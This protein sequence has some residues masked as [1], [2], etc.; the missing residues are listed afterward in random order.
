MQVACQRNMEEAEATNI[1][2]MAVGMRDPYWD[3]AAEYPDTDRKDEGPILSF[4]RTIPGK[5]HKIYLL[6]TRPGEKV[7]QP[8]AHRGDLT[9]RVLTG[10]YPDARVETRPLDGFDPSDYAEAYT[11][12]RK[13]IEQIVTENVQ[14]NGARYITNLSPGTP[15]MG[16]ALAVLH[17]EGRLPGEL[18]QTKAQVGAVTVSLAPLFEDELKSV[19]LSLMAT[20][21]YMAAS[22]LLSDIAGRSS[23][24]ERKEVA[25]AMA[26]IT[27]AYYWREQ[28]RYDLAVK[29]MKVAV[30][31]PGLMRLPP[32]LQALFESQRDT[33]K[34][35]SSNGD[36]L[37]ERL[38]DQHHLATLKHARDENAVCIQHCYM[39]VEQIEE[40]HPPG[41]PAN[42][43]KEREWLR[44]KR[45]RVAHEPRGT[46]KESAGR[47]LKFTETL[48]ASR[49]RNAR[50]DIQAY[51]LCL[52]QLRQ[53]LGAV[54]NH[55]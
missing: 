50:Q 16:V 31:L 32:R 19:V 3:D 41:V 24:P 9:S 53:V 43:Q 45:N 55:L 26:H 4:F 48:I 12:I 37:R 30:G 47:A 8:T 15:Q 28:F 22:Q 21:S 20:H 5:P 38:I 27:E 33:L 39:I 23:F 25:N 40:L 34:D 14:T 36:A 7:R 54:E 18:F 13:E 2:V 1:F 10:M 35:L 44:K 52:S 46:S 49:W 51:P 42:L 17:K 6:T 11:E 29:L